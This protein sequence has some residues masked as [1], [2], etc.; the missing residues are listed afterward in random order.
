MRFDMNMA[1][2]FADR[3]EQAN[4]NVY[5]KKEEQYESFASAYRRVKSV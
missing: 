5:G 2:D 4:K 3:L 1:S